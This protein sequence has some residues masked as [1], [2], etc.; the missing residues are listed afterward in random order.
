MQVVKPKDKESFPSKM[1]C[2]EKVIS[3]TVR[4]EWGGSGDLCVYASWR[5]SECRAE[6]E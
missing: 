2:C 4:T 1:V 6:A 3:P 5:C